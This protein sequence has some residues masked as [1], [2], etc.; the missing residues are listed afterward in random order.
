MMPRAPVF[1]FHDIVAADRLAEVPASHR[2][3][4][5]PPE[6]FR[7]FALAAK[8]T[9]RRAIPVGDV[10]GELG[11]HFYSFTFDDG[12]ESDYREAFP[13]L[14]ELGLR[15]TFFVVPTL[16]GTSGFAG[17]SELRE[18]V[19]CG[20]EIGSHSLTHPFVDRLDASAL[21]HEFGESK[22]IIEDRLGA[23]VRAAS[24]PRGW[25]P[26]ALDAILAELG[27]RVFCNSRVGWWRPG[28]NPLAVRRIPG[29]PGMPVDEFAA[30]VNAERRALWRLQLVDG[31]KAAVKACVGRRGWNRLREPLLRLRYE[32]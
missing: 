16:V 9:E 11:G 5:L 12:R 13:V 15:A 10:P 4:A 19:A 20:M 22:A 2:P 21:R 31:A 24:L 30:I 32:A 6:E 3:Y 29:E 1:L 14:C 25:A 17:W 28:A 8:A 26:P 18:M 27:Y 7:A 23:P